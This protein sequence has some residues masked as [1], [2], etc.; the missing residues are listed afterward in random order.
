[1]KKV[2]AIDFDGTIVEDAF[3]D[4]G[5]P[6]MRMFQFAKTVRSEGHKVVVWSCRA[7]KKLNKG[8]DRDY[9]QEM[10]DFLEQSNF[11]YDEIDDGSQGKYHADLY[12]DDKAVNAKAVGPNF[13]QTV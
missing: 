10:V 8:A 13:L 3:P 2:I 4:I 9:F 6:N 12:V 5:P 11:P 7:N 1:M